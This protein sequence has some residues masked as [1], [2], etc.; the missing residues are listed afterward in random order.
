[1]IKSNGTSVEAWVSVTGSCPI[2]CDVGDSRA[3]VR[4]GSEQSFALE[5][6]FTEDALEDLVRTAQQALRTMRSS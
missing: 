1:M 2:T 5:V 4:F 3:Q 6:L